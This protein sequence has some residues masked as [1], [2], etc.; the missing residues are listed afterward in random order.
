[1]SATWRTRSELALTIQKVCTFLTARPNTLCTHVSSRLEAARIE[2]HVMITVNIGCTVD[3]KFVRHVYVSYQ[4]PP[5][6][7]SRII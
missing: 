4:C 3:F 2:V 6:E 5:W 7:Q 1:M